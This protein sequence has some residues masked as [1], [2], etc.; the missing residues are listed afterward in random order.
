MQPARFDPGSN[1]SQANYKLVYR[2]HVQQ[3]Y[4][5]K[6][7]LL[8]L[9]GFFFANSMTTDYMDKFSDDTELKKW[10]IYSMK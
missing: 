1:I 5:G 4:A 2:Y 9:F 6:N 7:L 3:S 10:A 8:K